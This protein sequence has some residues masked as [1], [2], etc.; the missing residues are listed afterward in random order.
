MNTRRILWRCAVALGGLLVA[1]ASLGAQEK[2]SAMPRVDNAR[3]EQ[4]A[5]AGSL[6]ETMKGAVESTEARWI[7][8]AEPQ[9]ANDREICCQNYGGS[10]GNGNYGVCRL[11][12]GDHGANIT[13]RDT[14]GNGTVKLEGPRSVVVLF[15]AESKHFTKI[16]VVSDEC[17]L[18]AGGLPFLWLTGVKPADSVA[19]L[20]GYVH[21]GDFDEHGG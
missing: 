5:L 2:E 8:Y 13:T 7:G 10:W 18:D 17:T 16:R 6:A 4:R 12:S 9:V 21:G 20:T 1:T 14:G 15:R 19:F 11:E 3:V